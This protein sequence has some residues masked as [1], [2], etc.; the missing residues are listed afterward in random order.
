[1]ASTLHLMKEGEMK[2]GNERRGISLQEIPYNSL[3]SYLA[4]MVLSFIPNHQCPPC[5]KDYLF[6]ICRA[7][8]IKVTDLNMFT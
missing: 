1:M 5:M 3:F 4:L 6:P 8:N 2:E 7:Y